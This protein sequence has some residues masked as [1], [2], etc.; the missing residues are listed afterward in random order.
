MRN[1]RKNKLYIVHRKK[2][3]ALVNDLLEDYANVLNILLD[4]IVRMSRRFMFMT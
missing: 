2:M 4:L 1:I 3:K